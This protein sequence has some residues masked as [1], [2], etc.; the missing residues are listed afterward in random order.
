MMERALEPELSKRRITAAE[1]EAAFA[2]APQLRAGAAALA[3]LVGPWQKGSTRQGPGRVKPAPMASADSGAAELQEAAPRSLPRPFDTASRAGQGGNRRGVSTRLGNPAPEYAG[4]AETS[5]PRGQPNARGEAGG[6]SAL[7]SSFDIDPIEMQPSPD[8]APVDPLEWGNEP[9]SLGLGGIEL[10]GSPESA[11]VESL[12]WASGDAAAAGIPVGDT[13]LG[14]G[15]ESEEERRTTGTALGLGAEAPHDDPPAAGADPRGYG[16]MTSRG[17][18]RD[19]PAPKPGSDTSLGVGVQPAPRRRRSGTLGGWRPA[20]LDAGGSDSAS[21]RAAGSASKT[22]SGAG[23]ALDSAPVSASKTLGGIGSPVVTAPG[24]AGGV[25][26]GLTLA[27]GV[28]PLA[29]LN[30]GDPRL[31]GGDAGP[32]M[33]DAAGS[34]AGE[35]PFEPSPTTDRIGAAAAAARREAAGFEPSPNTRRLASD[36]PAADA[37]PAFELDL[38]SPPRG[39]VASP[40]AAHPVPARTTGGGSPWQRDA[41]SD[42]RPLSLGAALAIAIG[43]ALVVLVAGVWSVR[44]ARSLSDVAPPVAPSAAPAPSAAAV[45]SGSAKRA[46]SRKKKAKRPGARGKAKVAGSGVPKLPPRAL[47]IGEGD[48]SDLDPRKGYLRVH[49][50]GHPD[51]ELFYFGRSLGKAAGKH[52]V[53]CERTANL[54]IGRPGAIWLSEGRTVSVACQKITDVR[55]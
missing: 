23:V 31:G 17:L 1:L 44:Q 43:T 38:E 20:E 41:P 40:G 27:G 11:E 15:P 8:S 25:Q 28:H 30:T 22:L 13:N 19:R 47:E 18:G 55:F 6:L 52:V 32:A 14:L 42:D 16:P 24:K 10:Q 2:G 29:A 45:T 4:R 51:A 9:D 50:E 37:A 33:A 26:T 5:T 3:G 7:R 48:G 39:D 35:R 46:G 34:A 36:R 54:R 21:E 12:D 49:Y 53:D